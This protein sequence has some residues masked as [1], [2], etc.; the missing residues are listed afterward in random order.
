MGVILRG[1][2]LFV[3]VG[4]FF[5]PLFFYLK[6]WGIKPPPNRSHDFTTRVRPMYFEHELVNRVEL[7]KRLHAGVTKSCV[8]D[9]TSVISPDSAYN[10]ITTINEIFGI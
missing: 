1:V 9:I 4:C 10:I 8:L 2:S 7:V 6:N 5:L 3:I